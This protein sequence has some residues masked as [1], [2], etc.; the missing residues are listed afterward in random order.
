[1]VSARWNFRRAMLFC[2]PILQCNIPAAALTRA[3]SGTHRRT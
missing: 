2:A 1:M 3:L